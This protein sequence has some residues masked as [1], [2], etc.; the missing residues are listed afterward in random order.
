MAHAEILCGYSTSSIVQSK[1]LT[2]GERNWLNPLLLFCPLAKLGA[3]LT[4]HLGPLGVFGPFGD[5]L[6]NAT[7][8]IKVEGNRE[9]FAKLMTK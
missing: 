5:N 4:G 3:N 1:E 8:A 7:T 2:L 6:W 9:D